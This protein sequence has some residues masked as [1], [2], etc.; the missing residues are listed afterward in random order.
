MEDN[1]VLYK[2]CTLVRTSTRSH[3]SLCDA[4]HRGPGW[5]QAL[6]QML[7]RGWKHI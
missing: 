5:Q 4:I 3:I 7:L 1:A 6:P 2:N